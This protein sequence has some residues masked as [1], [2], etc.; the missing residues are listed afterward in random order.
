MNVF[1]LKKRARYR[2]EKLTDTQHLKEQ[3]EMQECRVL[4]IKHILNNYFKLRTI[5]KHN[6]GKTEQNL[7]GISAPFGFLITS[8]Y[9]VHL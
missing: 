5:M 7:L 4:K 8:A 3:V 9:N 6:A 2:A 1:I